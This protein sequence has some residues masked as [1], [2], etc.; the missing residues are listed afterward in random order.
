MSHIELKDLTLERTI[1]GVEM[2][3]ISGGI[4]HSLQQ[5]INQFGAHLNAQAQ[6]LFNPYYV[7]NTI[8]GSQQ[9]WRI[10]YGRQMPWN[11]R[12]YWM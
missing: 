3:S 10:Q 6:V 7:W 2:R 11:F 5:Q 8:R 9:A 12:P 4:T 1:T